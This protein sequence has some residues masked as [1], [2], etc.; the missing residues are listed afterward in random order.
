M[1][2]ADVA[3]TMS[4]RLF[5]LAVDQDGEGIKKRLIKILPEYKAMAAYQPE[6][7]GGSR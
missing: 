3:T 1:A 7:T 2:S 5:E 6:E 4:D